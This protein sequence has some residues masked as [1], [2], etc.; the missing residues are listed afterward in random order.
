MPKD[1]KARTEEKIQ[2]IVKKLNSE[3]SATRTEL[4]FIVREILFCRLPEG[5]FKK[6]AFKSYKRKDHGGRFQFLKSQKFI[7][8]YWSSSNGFTRRALEAI[9]V[10]LQL[11]REVSSRESSKNSQK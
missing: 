5:Q 2:E 9:Y 10:Q 8:T 7:K 1:P 4:F 3:G 6:P 11:G